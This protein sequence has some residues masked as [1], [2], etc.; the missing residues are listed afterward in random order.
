MEKAGSTHPN[1]IVH[2]VPASLV[3]C[4]EFSYYA[5]RDVGRSAI[6]ARVSPFEAFLKLFELHEA[7]IIHGDAHYCNIIALADGSYRWIDLRDP[8]YGVLGDVILLAKT[9]FDTAIDEDPT[10]FELALQYESEVSKE[11]M[12][13]FFEHCMD[14]MGK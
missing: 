7:G 4:K 9:V 12:I 13:S 2:V 5:L 11:R 8:Q 1:L 6:N 3:S 10:V 14:V